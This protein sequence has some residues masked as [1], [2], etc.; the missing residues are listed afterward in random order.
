[1]SL[2]ASS[3]ANAVGASVSNVP[4]GVGAAVLPRKT[5]II[6]TYDPAI[7]TI[8]DEVPALVLSP[9]DAANTYGAGYMIHRLVKA[10]MEGSNNTETWVL[11][12]VEVAGAQATGTVTVTG[13]ATA[14]GKIGRAHV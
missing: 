13:S 9:E 2:S 5:L 14:N 11:P 6:G 4:F 1:M 7:T 10:S 12:Q 3:R 8:T